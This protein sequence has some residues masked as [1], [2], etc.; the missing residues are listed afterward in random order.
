[1]TDPLSPGTP[2]RTGTSPLT[3]AR[4]AGGAGAALVVG[5]VLRF[6]SAFFAAKAL[7]LAGFG[8]YTLANTITVFLRI[9]GTVGLSP[10]ALPF[11]SRARKDGSA[12]GVRAVARVSLTLAAVMSS[13]LAM[14]VFV[15]AGRIA[16]DVFKDPALEPA[17]RLF[18]GLIV[19]GALTNVTRSL[20]VGMGAI[21]QQEWLERVLSVGATCGVLALAWIFGWGIE[22]AALAHYVGVGLAL[23]GG[24]IL[25]LPRLPRGQSGDIPTALP[26]TLFSHSWPLMGTTMLGFMLLW[27]DV[28]FVGF[29]KDADAVGMYG[30]GARLAA[31]AIASQEA[32]GP[33]LLA[34]AADHYVREEQAE[35]ASLYKLA[36]RW[37]MWP[38]LVMA[39]LLFVW[40]PELLALFG[41]EFLGGVV[42]MRIL[43]LGHVVATV[44]GMPGRMYSVTGLQRYHLFNMTLLL[45]GNVILNSLWIPRYG[46]AGA[47][48][49]T[50]TSLSVIRVVQTFQLRRLR[51]VFPWSR[52]TLRPVV[53]MMGLTTAA[54][55]MRDLGSGYLWGFGWILTSLAFVA[56]AVGLVIAVDM[57]P[58]DRELIAALRRRAGRSS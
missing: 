19:L 40:A 2:E 43:L 55:F 24:I 58:E 10:G 5:N 14:T 38:G 34:R 54:W 21:W 46:V 9:P 41:E 29:F 56:A 32:L 53:S 47:A 22:G 26:S 11:I 8:V 45:V 44:T 27:S 51:G 23:L 48:A 50:A 20:M 42:P 12:R 35:L 4:Q 7:G 6:V 17:L 37:A 39:S 30:A 18:A 25:L 1:M 33:I 3:V 13:V 52:R 15:L 28:L 31:A 16:N 36:V 49:A 57:R